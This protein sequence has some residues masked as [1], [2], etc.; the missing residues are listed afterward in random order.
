ML[1]K[2]FDPSQFTYDAVNDTLDINTVGLIN[3]GNINL[4]GYAIAKNLVFMLTS[5][6]V[7]PWFMKTDLLRGYN[8]SDTANIL[9]T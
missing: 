3:I 7:G 9:L 2:N 4:D 1:Q 8:L 6:D 5:N